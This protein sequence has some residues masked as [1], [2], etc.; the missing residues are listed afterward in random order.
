MPVLNT[1]NRNLQERLP[2]PQRS[3]LNDGPLATPS[4]LLSTRTIPNDATRVPRRLI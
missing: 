4:L 1:S 3:P 2:A